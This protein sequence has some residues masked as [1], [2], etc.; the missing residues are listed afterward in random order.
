MVRPEQLDRRGHLQRPVGRV[1]QCSARVY[2]STNDI[3]GLTVAGLTVNDKNTA[4]NPVTIGGIGF[5]I[6]ANGIDMSAA[7]TDL[8]VNTA[9]LT[10]TA[11]QTWTVAAGRTATINAPI[12]GSG[13]PP[14]GIGGTALCDST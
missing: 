2:S 6:A 13:T 9:G 1:Q 10:L 12:S 8:I 7:A 14:L 11:S 3:V 5:G 4:A